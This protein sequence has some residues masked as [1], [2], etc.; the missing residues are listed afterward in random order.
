MTICVISQ[1]TQMM[2]ALIVRGDL[3]FRG[4]TRKGD[5]N[6]SGEDDEVKTGP[7]EG[8]FRG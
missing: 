8:W 5:R 3:I 1:P 7:T 2:I 4:M 6:R